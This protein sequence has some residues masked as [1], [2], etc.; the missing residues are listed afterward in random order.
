MESSQNFLTVL[1]DEMFLCQ[2]QEIA[3]MWV[4]DLVSI[5]W[6]DHQWMKEGTTLTEDG[7]MKEFP[8]QSKP[9]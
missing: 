4:G 3:E 6:W 1:H 2:M 7:E 8:V 5:D 9:A